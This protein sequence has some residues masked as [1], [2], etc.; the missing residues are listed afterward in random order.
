VSAPL[1][2]SALEDDAAPVVSDMSTYL[3]S[4][5]VRSSEP[6]DPRLSRS[7]R[8]GVQDGVDAERLGFRRV[9]ISERHDIKEAG[10]ILGGV[11]ALTSHVEIG[12]GAV[13]VPSR[14]P[15]MAA[16]LGATMQAAYG[17]R[18]ILGLGRGTGGFM[19]Q[20]AVSYAALS[21][22]VQIIRRLWRGETVDYDGPAGR[23]AGIRLQDTYDGPQPQ[24]WGVLLGGPK[25]C[26]TAANIYDG[27]I[28][29]PFL[30]AEA[31][32]NAVGWIRGECERIERDPT[33]IRI[34]H[35][36]VAACELDDLETRLL[37][38]ARAVTYFQYDQGEVWMR[39]NGWPES[40]CE[41]LRQHA[42]LK[43]V[44]SADQHFHRRDLLG[45]ASLIPDSWMHETCAIG[46]PPEC[47][48]TLR[49]YREAG[50]DEV[51]LY[52]SAP[53]QN[54]RLIA[55]WRERSPAKR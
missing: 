13:S 3:I 51:I 19:G 34:C 44:A 35:P 28:L 10:V 6:D 2:S 40:F 32:H 37:C 38:H 1:T 39:L 45:P 11:G 23:Y 52:G 27:V 54:A 14:D 16:A 21:D 15:R 17:P 24:I 29:N 50:A 33:S 31:V 46:S 25:A 42:Q 5:R 26:R 41:E 7:V 9:F 12:T 30:T 20:K 47:V 49:R 53:S 22:Y 48:T 43:A 36:I 55:A 4:G 8:Q 18:F